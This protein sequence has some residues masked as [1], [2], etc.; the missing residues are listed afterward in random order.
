MRKLYLLICLVMLSFAW[1]CT[2][3]STDSTTS[4]T[5]NMTTS[6]TSLDTWEQ[7]VETRLDTE[8][9]YI[10][11]MIPKEIT[12][13]FLLPE[14]SDDE[15]SILYYVDGDLLNEQV[16]VYVPSLEGIDISLQIELRLF[17]VILSG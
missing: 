1:S 15:I 10:E 7:W 14:P 2:Q 17:D 13:D 6:E 5:T 3:A 9:L 8:L 12:A 4:L 16:I 11:S